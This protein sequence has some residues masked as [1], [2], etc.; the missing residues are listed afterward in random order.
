[1]TRRIVGYVSFQIGWLACALGAARG[2]PMIGPVVVAA[3]FGLHLALTPDRGCEIRLA[4]AIGV[5]GTVV[6]SLKAATGF[7]SYVGGYPGVDWLCPLWITAMWVNYAKA[8]NTS[9]GW[10][11][12]RYLLAAILG[13]IAGPLN[14]LAGSRLGALQLNIDMSSGIVVLAVVWGIVVPLTFWLAER[15]K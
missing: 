2:L 11:K 1:M 10:L 5:V 13:A 7:I 8:L 12:G 9:L 15:I 4:V 14:Y 3:L 6:D